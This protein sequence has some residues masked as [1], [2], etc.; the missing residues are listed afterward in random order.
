MIRFARQLAPFSNCP[1]RLLQLSD[2]RITIFM[3]NCFF[4]KGKSI[5]CSR[6]SL[7]VDSGRSRMIGSLAQIT[8]MKAY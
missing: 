2:L 4:V 6:C 3:L 5:L 7:E 1:N 8:G